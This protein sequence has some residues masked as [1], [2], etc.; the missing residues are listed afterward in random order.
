MSFDQRFL[1]TREPVDE[2]D[3][4]LF[5]EAIVEAQDWRATPEA[6]GLSISVVGNVIELSI[7]DA[8]LVDLAALNQVIIDFQGFDLGEGNTLE[9]ADASK[10]GKEDLT[11]QIPVRLKNALSYDLWVPYATVDSDESAT[12]TVVQDYES[13]SSAITIPAGTTEAVLP[14]DVFAD[15]AGDPSS[16]TFLDSEKYDTNVDV[17]S[18]SINRPTGVQVGD[19]LI[20]IH[21]TQGNGNW[22]TTPSGWTTLYDDRSDP[23]NSNSGCHVL[24][25]KKVA[26]GS[27]PS[28]YDYAYGTNADF[29]TV[30]LAYRGVDTSLS[31]SDIVATK[32]GTDIT[33]IVAPSVTTV[34]ANS[35]LITAHGCNPSTTGSNQSFSTPAGMTERY[36]SNLTGSGTTLRAGLGVFEQNIAVA[37]ATGTRTSTASN[38]G[39]AIALSMYLTPIASQ[40]TTEGSEFFF[41]SLGTPKVTNG[42]GADSDILVA[43]AVAKITILPDGL[44]EPEEPP[45]GDEGGG[46]M[47]GWHQLDNDISTA[48][49]HEGHLGKNFACVRYFSSTNLGRPSAQAKQLAEDHGGRLM[50][51]SVKADNWVDVAAGNQNAWIDAVGAELQSWNVEQVIFIF[52]HEPHDNSN[53]K[54]ESTDLTEDPPVYSDEDDAAAGRTAVAYKAVYALINDRWGANNYLKRD[55]AGGKILIGYCA[56]DD[57]ALGTTGSNLAGAGIDGLYPDSADVDV[58]CHD[59]YNTINGVPDL[60]FSDI[61]EPIVDLCDDLGK[62]LIIGEVGSKPGAEFHANLKTSLGGTR[63]RDEWFREAAAWMKSNT[64][65]R[66]WLKG[67]CYYHSR[68]WMFLNED[69][70]KHVSGYSDK[71]SGPVGGVEGKD[72]WIAAFVNDPDGYFTG[73]PFNPITDTGDD[74]PTSSSC[75]NTYNGTLRNDAVPNNDNGEI[76]GL[77]SSKVHV[78]TIWAIKDSPD[79]PDTGEYL[80]RLKT[81]GTTG[82]YTVNKIPIIGSDNNDWEDCFYSYEGSQGYIY[83]HDNRDGNREGVKARR[84]YKVVE[85]ANPDT[86]PSTS[87]AATY[88]WKFHPTASTDICKMPNYPNSNQN[89]EAMFMYPVNN[90]GTNGIIYAVLKK[91]SVADIYIVGNPT[92][93]QISTNE[94]QPTIATKIGSIN[95]GCPSSFAVNLEGDRVI[96]VSHG[97]HRVWK[98]IAG[99]L[100]SFFSGSPELFELATGTT[101]NEEAADWFPFGGCGLQ[102]IAEN[103]KGWIYTNS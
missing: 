63:D 54:N 72:G 1:L 61:W 46:V 39:Q 3:R 81:T 45:S 23:T 89:C 73:I 100:E 11:V 80:M 5:F 103:R 83:I 99:S 18:Y 92:L 95:H 36:D 69:G 90:G 84:L 66:K 77:A 15:T 101:A 60:K 79:A 48:R 9:I 76:S 47:I 93:G 94:S 43:R 70:T 102:V 41:V 38:N 96:T 37:G 29:A 34:A 13:T 62:P 7:P 25:Q 16:I 26:T 64:N 30:I 24:V 88:Y 27:E 57:W 74:T 31:P 50:L 78:N 56:V 87:I 12:A 22:T 8:W 49:L 6:V 17:T 28:T 98:G 68:R 33:S 51:W 59:G 44:A 42:A 4:D 65:A 85:P 91:K 82:V 58:L 35:L 14:V 71:A 19:L 21:Q 97:K 67:F 40:P 32:T 53:M 20:A 2:T 10:L 86:D 52:Y 75:G 55:E